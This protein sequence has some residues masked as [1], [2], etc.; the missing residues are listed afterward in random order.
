MLSAVVT[1]RRGF[2]ILNK[3]VVLNK[4]AVLTKHVDELIHYIMCDHSI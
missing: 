2:D 3:H 4:H 1:Y